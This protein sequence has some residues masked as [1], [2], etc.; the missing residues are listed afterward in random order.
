MADADAHAPVVVGPV[1]RDR[2]Q[3]VVAGIA[4]AD[5]DPHFARREIEFVVQHEDVA[6]PRFCGTARPPARRG[7]SRSCTSAAPAARL[8]RRRCRLRACA[9]G[10]SFSTARSGAVGNALDRHEAELWRLRAYLWPGLPRPTKSFMTT[11]PSAPCFTCRPIPIVSRLPRSPACRSRQRALRRRGGRRCRTLAFQFAGHIQQAAEIAGKQQV[12]LRRSD[13]V[14]LLLHHGVRDV[15]ILDRERATEAAADLAVFHLDER[16]ALDR[17][18]QR[19]RLVLDAEFAQA[20][21]TVVI[22][23]ASIEASVDAGQPR[24][25]VRNESSSECRAAS[26]PPEAPEP[27]HPSAAWDNALFSMPPHE[28]DGTTT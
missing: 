18:E 20:R 24:T 27:H 22:G 6:Y 1:R 7:R 11:S 13:V 23:G 9:L 8:F 4:A 5:F 25:S 12:G 19:P 14:D 16:Q 15:G 10:I 21:A 26:F 3:A 28:P 17:R 2:S